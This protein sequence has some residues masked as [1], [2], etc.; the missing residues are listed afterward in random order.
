MT[1]EVPAQH[2]PGARGPLAAAA[3]ILHPHL[4]GV[5]LLDVVTRGEHAGPGR[6]AL[7]QVHGCAACTGRG[8]CAEGTGLVK[9]I[10]PPRTRAWRA[11][12]EVEVAAASA[13]KRC[14]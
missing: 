1:R 3:L 12:V 14:R 6:E 9:A 4:P 10:T 8:L 13:R 7:L 2:E 11:R 5:S